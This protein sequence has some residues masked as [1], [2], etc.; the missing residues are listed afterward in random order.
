[1]RV[2]AALLSVVAMLTL[3][4]LYVSEAR[5]QTVAW[6]ASNGSDANPCTLALPCARFADAHDKVGPG[7]EIRC[8]DPGNYQG[9]TISKSITI[10]CDNSIGSTGAGAISISV[11]PSDVVVLKGIDANGNHMNFG[12]VYVMSITGAGTVQLHNVKI[13]GFIGSSGALRF[14][15]SGAA[16]LLVSN[17][18]FSDNGTGGNILIRPVMGATASA[19]F[20]HVTSIGSVFGIKADGGGQ[21]G[22]QINVEVRDS[23][24]ALNVNN[25]FVAASNSGQAPITFKIT[26]SASFGNGAAGAVASGAQVSMFVSNSTFT[27]NGF[28]LQQLAG[29]TFRS[30]V[31]ND[32]NSNGTDIVGTV[33][34]ISQ[35]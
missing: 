21:A 13:S 26:G 10:D 9:L 28:G 1:M 35:R 25:G 15:P 33:T 7:S 12:A 27:R 4:A 23:V 22:G 14:A 20:D 11:G 8:V 19:I 18:I 34:P 17:S 2:S 16:K 3:G 6:V 24:A 30:Y 32:V 5:A 31:N 29:S